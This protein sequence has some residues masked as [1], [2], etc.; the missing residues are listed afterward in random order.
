MQSQLLASCGFVGVIH[1]FKDDVLGG[2]R[3]RLEST[4]THAG[5]TEAMLNEL[6]AHAADVQALTDLDT[7]QHTVAAYRLLLRKEGKA[8]CSPFPG[9]TYPTGS[10]AAMP[11]AVSPFSTAARTWGFGDLTI[12]V[13]CHE[14]LFQQFHTGHLRL[15]AASAVVPAPLSPDRTAE[16]FRCAQ[17]FV[18]GDRTPGRRLPG[19]GVLARRSK[20]VRVPRSATAS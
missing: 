9:H 12:K 6:R 16:V 4:E 15:G 11:S 3:Q 8:R 2:G 19:L 10:V 13:A 5:A 1:D 20:M 14:V 18:P 17:C 7:I